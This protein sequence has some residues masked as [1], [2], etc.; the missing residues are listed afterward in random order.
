LAGASLSNRGSAA[1]ASTRVLELLQLDTTF[2]QDGGSC[3]LASYAVVNN[4]F[5]SHPIEDVF[6]DYC[7]HFKLPFGDWEDA[8]KHYADHFDRE[9]KKRKCLGYEVILD[10]HTNSEMSSFKIGRAAFDAGLYRESAPN[11][12]EL[13]RI[14][15][16]KEAILNITFQHPSGDCHSVT[17]FG[18]PTGFAVRDTNRKGLEEISKLSD[19]GNL[20]DSVLYV[21]KLP[22]AGGPL[23]EAAA[24]GAPGQT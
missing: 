3:V 9:W 10:L 12:A 6:R 2:I 15:R 20:R 1:E 23:Q 18:T 7:R 8:E 11:S 22:A 21:K 17:A 5:T 16:S 14:L 19:L 24:P 13:E 4:C